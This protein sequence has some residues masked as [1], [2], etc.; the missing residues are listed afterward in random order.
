MYI[1]IFYFC[2]VC[3]FFKVL[4]KIDSLIIIQI[5]VSFT[6]R[7]LRTTVKYTSIIRYIFL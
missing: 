1:C 4:K 6:E 5:I 3:V 7:C 2:F